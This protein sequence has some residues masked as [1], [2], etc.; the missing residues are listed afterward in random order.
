M[1][2]ELELLVCN[3]MLSWSLRIP[4]SKRGGREGILGIWWNGFASNK[5]PGLQRS[6]CLLA[7]HRIMNSSSLKS[8]SLE[9]LFVFL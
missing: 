2:L 8:S 7:I 9:S 3:G 1:L 4:L 5:R 6:P